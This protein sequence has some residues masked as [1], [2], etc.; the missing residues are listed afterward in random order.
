MTH[1]PDGPGGPPGRRRPIPM[2]LTVAVSVFLAVLVPVYWHLYGWTNFLWYCDFALLVTTAGL[3]AQS[4]LLL[5]IA[6]V[7]ILL[8]Q[9]FWL[10]DFG[11]HLAGWHFLDLTNYMFDPR[12]SWFI[13]GLSLFHGWLPLLLVWALF[14]VG[15]DHRA[16]IVWTILAAGLLVLDY[17]F[18]LP[19]G[20]HPAN[21]NTPINVNLIYGFD[22]GRPQALLNEKLYVPLWFCGLW[23]CLWLPTHLVLQKCFN[24]P[25]VT[26]AWKPSRCL[27]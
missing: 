15:Y 27:F 25:R 2:A 22:D 16:L 26:P 11:C 14:R 17:A 13:R 4:S 8:P 12:L 23:L 1:H 7:G 10:A 21:P 9:C 19:A 6:A 20:A 5:S 18:T 24:P 3:C